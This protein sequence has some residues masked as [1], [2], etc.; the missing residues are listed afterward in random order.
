[1][2]CNLRI[3]MALILSAMIV[4]S[5]LTME[6]P[7]ST[8]AKFKNGT[9]YMVKGLYHGLAKT[10]VKNPIG[11]CLGLWRLLIENDYIKDNPGRSVGIASSLLVPVIYHGFFDDKKIHNSVL[12]TFID[13]P[14]MCGLALQKI[15][16]DR[17]GIRNHP[18]T[19]AF[20][21]CDI[22]QAFARNYNE[23]NKKD[24]AA[25]DEDEY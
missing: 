4:S 24:Q 18:W 13:T 25:D 23:L 1:M 19:S 10:V 6:P 2:Y 17:E 8:L 11:V 22:L 20:V 9:T 12:Q 16:F 15:C 21:A 3:R 5:A 14:Y 7:Q